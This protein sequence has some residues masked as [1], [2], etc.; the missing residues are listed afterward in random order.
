MPAKIARAPWNDL[1]P[2]LR[3]RDAFD[4]VVILLDNVVEIF[5]QPNRDRYFAFLVQLLQHSQITDRPANDRRMV[6]HHAAFL[7]HFFKVPIT[8][9]VSCVPANSN[10]NHVHWKSVSFSIQHGRLLISERQ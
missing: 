8:Q 9:E 4:P 7:H 1:K 2:R 10:Q 5:D 3:P 6:N